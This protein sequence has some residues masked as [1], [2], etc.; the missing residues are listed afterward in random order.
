[1]K[2]KAFFAVLAFAAS[3]PASACNLDYSTASDIVKKV[4][5]R[6]GWT[7]PNYQVICEKMNRANAAI[8]ISGDAVVLD[9]KSIA[10]S[11]VGLKDKRSN[12]MSFDFGGISTKT[13]PYASQDKAE[14]MLDESINDAISTLAGKLDLALA[15][16]DEAR[17]NVYNARR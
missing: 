8:V 3:M 5:A 14:T 1:M 7:F 12:I 4:M 17:K 13:N 10:W 6:G 15:R 9:G 2:I 11:A 16:L